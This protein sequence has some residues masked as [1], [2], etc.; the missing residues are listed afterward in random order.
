MTF[1]EQ[2]LK[3]LSED[4]SHLFAVPGRTVFPLLKDVNYSKIQCVICANE[5]GAGFMAE[6]YAKASN[7]YGVALTVAGAGFNNI[8]PSL[9]NAYYDN[10]RVLFIVGT[11]ETHYGGRNIFQD[12]SISQMN[13]HYISSSLTS[14]SCL[15]NDSDY[16]N[17]YSNSLF[18]LVHK[19]LPVVMS[20]PINVQSS[21]VSQLPQ[22]S[23]MN[24]SVLNQS[25]LKHMKDV[26]QN[27]RVL[28]VTGTRTDN[29]RIFINEFCR[30]YFIYSASTLC[31]KGVIDEFLDN[32]LG[33]F[34]FGMSPRIFELMISNELDYIITI[35]M[36]INERNT[37]KW[38]EFKHKII[39][40]DEDINHN[41]RD[42]YFVRDGYVANISVLF[43]ALLGDSELSQKLLCSIN[44]RRDYICTLAL[45]KTIDTIHEDNSKLYV[46]QVLRVI[47]NLCSEN[48]NFVTDSG[49]HRLYCAQ[50]LRLAYSSKY[51]S[52]VNN[53]HMGWAIAA[54]I[55]VR[56]ADSVRDCICI[57][58]DG[59]ML[60]TGMEIQTA[61]KYKV[62]ILFIV[63]NNCAHGA[64]KNANIQYPNIGMVSHQYDI[65]NHDWTLFARSLGVSSVDIKTLNQL[66][67]ALEMFKYSEEPLLL[68]VICHYD[69]NVNINWYYEEFVRISNDGNK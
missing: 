52:S 17:H 3:T 14:Y 38:S 2:L 55:G 41:S 18:N 51:Y 68:N 35:G 54:S 32:Y 23:K 11:A 58:G 37:Y 46:D 53:G 64:I 27:S 39:H 62:K 60:M 33:I 30:K 9:I 36:D 13:S 1:A 7:K 25:A 20:I 16:L 69:S 67:G 40:I 65:P 59:C 50:I 43:E 15:M 19:S 24:N 12:S 44:S 6:G 66:N 4:I 8:F 48:T 49:L 57:T 63:I 5:T 21:K 31:S 47:N 61:A 34:G 26:L 56:L 29:A 45:P 10:T 28:L 42:H 22:I